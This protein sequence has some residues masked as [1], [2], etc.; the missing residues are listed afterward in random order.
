MNEKSISLR[1]LAIALA[2]GMSMNAMAGLFGP[3]GTSWKEEVLLHDGSRIIATREVE[4]GGRHEIGQEPPIKQ[5]SLS[6]D[7]PD[8]HGKIVWQDKFSEDVGGANFN[9]KLLDIFK[10]VPYV[11]GMPAGCFS[12]NKWGRPNP[13]YV[14]FRYDGREWLRISL[15]E[16]PDEIKTPNLIPSS[17]DHAALKAGGS[18]VSAEAIKR[19]Y[20]DYRQPEYKTILRDPLPQERCPQYSSGPKPPIPIIPGGSPK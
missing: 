15:K 11:M 6:F 10:G 2:M 5:Q 9:L 4:R 20:E 14:V 18:V 16:L 13:P 3:G 12:Y 1:V 19:L 7:M 8:A 17:P